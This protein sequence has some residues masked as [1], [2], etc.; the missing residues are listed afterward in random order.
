MDRSLRAQYP[1]LGI[2]F[3]K[4]V[5]SD[6]S[7]PAFRGHVELA[8]DD[9]RAV[10]LRRPIVPRRAS[11]RCGE[12]P[13]DAVVRRHDAQDLG[14]G[15]GALGA[16]VAP[17]E[18]SLD[19][20]HERQPAVEPQ[21]L[22]EPGARALDGVA[23]ARPLAAA[24]RLVEGPAGLAQPLVDA[25]LPA[26]FQGE[27]PEEPAPFDAPFVVLDEPRPPS[28]W[29]RRRRTLDYSRP[30]PVPRQFPHRKTMPEQAC[31]G[32]VGHTF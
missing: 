4:C 16:H 23:G 12:Q 1:N 8:P 17:P 27:L 31:Q 18:D 26:A 30:R 2:C 7:L 22:P 15:Q 9:S 13:V 10:F 28:S 29:R 14:G 25:L 19:S 20:A 3:K 5:P 6:Y 21:H 32:E 11:R 24:H